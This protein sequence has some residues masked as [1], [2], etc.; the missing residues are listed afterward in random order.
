MSVM[1]MIHEVECNSRLTTD[2]HTGSDQQWKLS[3]KKKLHRITIHV[4]YYKTL[5]GPINSNYISSM[6]QMISIL[7]LSGALSQAKTSNHSQSGWI[8]VRA[9]WRALA[10]ICDRPSHHPPWCPLALWIQNFTENLRS[11]Y[12]KSVHHH[13]VVISL[14]GWIL[15]WIFYT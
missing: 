12:Q 1:I 5:T 4:I 7:N 8:C 11:R 15:N 14:W 6:S 10:G 3:W 9:W 2:N 13:H